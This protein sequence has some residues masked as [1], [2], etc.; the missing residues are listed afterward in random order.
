MPLPV[1]C[2]TPTSL[3][4]KTYLLPLPIAVLRLRL[5]IPSMRRI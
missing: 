3:N 2:L 4:L 1:L 5:S